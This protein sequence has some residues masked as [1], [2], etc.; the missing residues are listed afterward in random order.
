MSPGYSSRRRASV[1]EAALSYPVAS[2]LKSLPETVIVSARTLPFTLRLFEP[3]IF[4]RP[5]GAMMKPVQL[6]PL[7]DMSMALSWLPLEKSKTSSK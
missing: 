6:P 1:Q 3:W 7:P 2:M 4:T 5:S